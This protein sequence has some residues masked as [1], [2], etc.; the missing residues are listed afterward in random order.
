M[1]CMAKKKARRDSDAVTISRSSQWL[2][3]GGIFTCGAVFMMG[4]IAFHQGQGESRA[5]AMKQQSY[6]QTTCTVENAVAATNR[7]AE[8]SEYTIL[9]VT[10]KLRVGDQEYSGLTYEYPS[11]AYTKPA[12]E[13][14]VARE[15]AKGAPVT[16]FYDKDKP[17]DAVLRLLAAPPAE[18]PDPAGAWLLGAAGAVLMAFGLY[19]ALSKRRWKAYSD[20]DYG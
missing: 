14:A 6:V 10:F 12:A 1:G 15:L 11:Y 2:I 20:N 8:G 4:A 18:P 7:D 19:F 17:T 9:T 13:Q 3:G 5:R 16:C